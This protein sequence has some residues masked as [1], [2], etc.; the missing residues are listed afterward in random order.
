[1][2][3]FRDLAD[4]RHEIELGNRRGVVSRSKLPSKA[5]WSWDLDAPQLC[6]QH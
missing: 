5:S 4:K 1:M 2:K 3:Y 6:Q